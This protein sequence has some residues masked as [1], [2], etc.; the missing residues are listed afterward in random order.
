ME[1]TLSSMAFWCLHDPDV[2]NWYLD[3][4]QNSAWC[5]DGQTVTFSK[6]AIK[7][8]TD[9]NNREGSSGA[10]YMMVFNCNRSRNGKFKPFGSP[11]RYKFSATSP[12]D[13]CSC[14]PKPV[15]D[16]S[17]NNADRNSGEECRRMAWGRKEKSPQSN[18]IPNGLG[19]RAMQ[20][21]LI[22]FNSDC[23]LS[24]YSAIRYCRSSF[25]ESD[26]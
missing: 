16:W 19:P 10:R 11:D 15:A 2:R 1:L 4:R 5:D 21:Y 9:Y 13:C 26:G 7:R 17:A 14:W 6:R 20:F 24:T 3:H 18:S 12:A 22:I 25:C 8:G 23:S